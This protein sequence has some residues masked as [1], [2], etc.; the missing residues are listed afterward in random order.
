M[1]AVAIH[2]RLLFFR[3]LFQVQRLERQSYWRSL[4]NLTDLGDADQDQLSNKRKRLLSF[5]KSLKKGS[6]GIPPLRG[7]GRVHNDP[8]DKANILNRQY[9]SEFTDEDNI[10]IPRPQVDPSLTMPDSQVTVEGVLTE[11]EQGIRTSYDI[12]KDSQRTIRSDSPF[13]LQYLSEVSRYRTDP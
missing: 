2:Y 12:C 6:S 8:L 5:T 11:P 7:Q 10:N 3:S 13:P 1:V 4:E 9:Q